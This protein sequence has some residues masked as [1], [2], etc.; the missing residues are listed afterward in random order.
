M[1]VEKICDN[2]N[3][4]F[5]ESKIRQHKFCFLIPVYFLNSTSTNVTSHLV[6]TVVHGRSDTDRDRLENRMKV[7]RNR[8]KKVHI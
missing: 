8:E 2:A 6:E 4:S 3:H 1:T 5:K 7:T